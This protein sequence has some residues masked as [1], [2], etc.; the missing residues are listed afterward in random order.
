MTQL[1]D[2]G[3]RD[4]ERINLDDTQDVSFWISELETSKEE[5]KT[6]VES[7]GTD[8]RKVRTYLAARFTRF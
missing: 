3:S 8:A 4:G 6:A 7:V 2:R 1:Q 5:L